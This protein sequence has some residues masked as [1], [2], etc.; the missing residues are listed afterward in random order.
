MDTVPKHPVK[1]PPNLIRRGA[2]SLDRLLSHVY[3]GTAQESEDFEL[4]F[5]SSAI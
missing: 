4:A 3:P 5:M 2:F 1:E